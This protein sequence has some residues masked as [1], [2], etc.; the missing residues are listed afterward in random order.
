MDY[1]EFI[2][3]VVSHIPDKGQVTIRYFGLYANAHR[4]KVKKA[5]QVPVFPGMIEG[6]LRP[7]PSKRWAA[8]IN[9]GHVANSLQFGTCPLLRPNALPSMRRP[10][11][12]NRFPDGVCPG[13]QYH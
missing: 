3:R 11:E 9:W 12:G 2:A 4:G 5:S 8:L 1:L 13:Q 10:D 6:E 7:T